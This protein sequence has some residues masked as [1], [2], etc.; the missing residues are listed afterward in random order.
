MPEAKAVL[1]KTIPEAKATAEAK[2]KTKVKAD[3]KGNGKVKVEAD[4]KAKAA[5]TAAKEEVALK[6]PAASVEP[7]V[8][9]DTE[10][11]ATHTA[12]KEAEVMLKRP[13]ASVE[14]MVEFDPAKVYMYDVYKKLRTD[15]PR[16]KRNAFTCRAYD[17]GKRRAKQAGAKPP[18]RTEFARVHLRTAAELLDE[19]GS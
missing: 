13:A 16:M 18:T 12:A 8:E 7:M 4:T 1:T 5:H 11:K 9:A 15:F 3:V 2:V 14:T 19:L 6:R 17:T 10:A